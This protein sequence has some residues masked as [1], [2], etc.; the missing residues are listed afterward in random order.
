MAE[1]TEVRV[2]VMGVG[3]MGEVHTRVL[4]DTPGVLVRGRPTPMRLL[5]KRWGSVMAFPVIQRIPR[6]CCQKWMPW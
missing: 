4:V 2:G 5:R 3:F 6:I 1:A